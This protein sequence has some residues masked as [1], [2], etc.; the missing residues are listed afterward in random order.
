MELRAHI[1]NNSWFTNCKSLKGLIITL[2][3]LVN[4]ITNINHN[5]HEIPKGI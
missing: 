1:F 3:L 2:I 4:Y 5:K